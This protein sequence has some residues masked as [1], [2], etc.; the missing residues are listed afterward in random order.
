MSLH[1]I[2]K[3][4][5][6]ADTSMNS[7]RE[8]TTWRWRRSACVLLCSLIQDR[9][10]SFRG[11]Y[12]GVAKTTGLT[13]LQMVRDVLSCRGRGTKPVYAHIHLVQPGL[14]TRRLRRLVA[15]NIHCA[16]TRLGPVFSLTTSLIIVITVSA[17]VRQYFGVRID[18]QA[19]KRFS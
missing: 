1:G 14:I 11:Q 19:R 2:P 8:C 4:L 6:N 12:T 18:L 17:N 16:C 3:N 13:K 15:S 9:V 10:S 7:L 5:S